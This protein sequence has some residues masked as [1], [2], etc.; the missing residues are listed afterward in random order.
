MVPLPD[1]IRAAALAAGYALGLELYGVDFLLPQDGSGDFAVVDVNAFPG[2]NGLDD[3][4]AALA[5]YLFE[6]AR[7]GAVA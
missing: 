4:P 5:D 6:R 2:Y 3:A 1:S 7:L